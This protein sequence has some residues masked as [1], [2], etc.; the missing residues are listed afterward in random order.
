M[1][2][3]IGHDMHIKRGAGGARGKFGGRGQGGGGYGKSRV[4]QGGTRRP[5]DDG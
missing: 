3:V 5:Q 4:S 2:G 1:A